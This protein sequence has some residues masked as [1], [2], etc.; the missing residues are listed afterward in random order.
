MRSPSTTVTQEVLQGRC[1]DGSQAAVIHVEGPHGAFD[2][3]GS[4][5]AIQA[6]MDFLANLRSVAPQVAGAIS[7]DRS[8]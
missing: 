7:M 3:V 8:R 4:T 6:T 1:S 2:W 5:D